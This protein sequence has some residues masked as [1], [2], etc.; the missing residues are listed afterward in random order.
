MRAPDWADRIGHVPCGCNDRKFI[1]NEAGKI[2]LWQA[3]MMA[4]AAG[5]ILY[6]AVKS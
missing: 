6:V 5:I 3:A 1:M 4:V 2:G